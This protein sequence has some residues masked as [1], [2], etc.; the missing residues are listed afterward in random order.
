MKARNV[1]VLLDEPASS[2]LPREI[3]GTEV[4]GCIDWPAC[5]T[6][7]DLIEAADQRSWHRLLDRH[8]SRHVP[9]PLQAA[10]RE[11][12]T[13]HRPPRSAPPPEW[14]PGRRRIIAN[15]IRRNWDQATAEYSVDDL[16]FT[17]DLDAPELAGPAA[18]YR[19]AHTYLREPPPYGRV[20]CYPANDETV[21]IV[22]ADERA[23]ASSAVPERRPLHTS[24]STPR[25]T[26]STPPR[27]PRRP[28]CSRV[29]PNS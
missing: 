5:G 2:A 29:S 6:C 28:N 19:A 7:H 18:A 23:G 10:W 16:P 4:V 12:W 26:P 27:A 9:M 17:D 22:R 21:R 3:L 1:R 14:T 13:N 24:C 11:F 20:R 15:H 25:P 8:D